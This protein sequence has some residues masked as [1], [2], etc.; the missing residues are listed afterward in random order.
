MQG[1]EQWSILSAIW[2]CLADWR[3]CAVFL[4]LCF[5][6]SLPI[7]SLSLSLWK[8]LRD[9]S[10]MQEKAGRKVLPISCLFYRLGAKVV[11]THSL[12]ILHTFQA[13]M[14]SYHGRLTFCHHL[15]V[16][17][18][19]RVPLLFSF[20][21]HTHSHLYRGAT[22]SQISWT[23]F[24]ASRESSSALTSRK[25]IASLALSLSLRFENQPPSSLSSQL[26]Q[27]RELSITCVSWQ[28]IVGILYSLCVIGRVVGCT[29]LKKK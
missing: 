10:L 13:Y 3:S 19:F 11:H 29:R 25:K 6:I 22:C 20:A 8:E 15:P 26:R 14:Q 7:S 23:T 17:L 18:N 16:H 5:M 27:N 24:R 9:T 28:R 2:V 1:S 4:V 21:I 12:K